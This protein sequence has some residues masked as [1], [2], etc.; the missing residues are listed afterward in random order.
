VLGLLVWLWSA[1]KALP[2]RER[3]H[4]WIPLLLT[5]ALVAALPGSHELRYFSFWILELVFLCFLT[6]GRPREIPAA[7]RAF[8]LAA[9]LAVVAWTGGRSFDARP[10]GV[11]DHIRA[12]GIDAAVTGEDLCFEHRNRDPVL[13]THLFHAKGRYHVVDLPPGERCPAVAPRS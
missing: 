4:R 5:S 10:Y 9:F 13:F 12:H 2:G 1:T 8:L 11:Q 7:A 6:T 3:L